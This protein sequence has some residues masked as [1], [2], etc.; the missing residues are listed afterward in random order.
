MAFIE[1][2][3]PSLPSM[4]GKAQQFLRQ[5]GGVP[6]TLAAS[7]IPSVGAATGLGTGGAAGM[8]HMPSNGANGAVN[9]YLGPGFDQ[10]LTINVTFPST[11]PTL[12]W[13]CNFGTFEVSTED[14][15]TYT[16][17]FSEV[18]GIARS[19]PW[20]VSFQPATAR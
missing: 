18:I 19:E 1:T 9:V 15:K 13:S 17:T 14:D 16:L 20:L 3:R 10:A 6:Q 4:Q 5:Y 8:A 7:N 12:F 2:A 11:P